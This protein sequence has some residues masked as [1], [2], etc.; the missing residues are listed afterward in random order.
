MLDF[1]FF[2]TAIPAVI[3]FGISKG[4]FAGPIA[5]LSIPLMSLTMSPQTAA[6]ILLPILLVMDF[7]ALYIYWKKWDLKN[8]KIIIPPAIFGILIGSLT[9]QYSSDD[10]IRIIIGTIAILFIVLT[11]IQKN[12]FL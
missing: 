11:I 9:F 5:I 4:G 10:S 1:Y 12:N 7:V 2:L 6:G 8:I 3:L